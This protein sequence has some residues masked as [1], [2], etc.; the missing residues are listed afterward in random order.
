MT[1]WNMGEMSMEGQKA[2][3][4]MSLTRICQSH[5]QLTHPFQIDP[6]EYRN[7]L[8]LVPP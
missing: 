6:A 7:P 4:R 8:L 5:Y 1:D 3:W 2:E